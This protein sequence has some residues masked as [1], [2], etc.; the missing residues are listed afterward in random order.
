MGRSG[1]GG[2]DGLFAVNLDDAAVLDVTHVL[3][4]VE[5][6]ARLVLDQDGRVGGLQHAGGQLLGEHVDD[7][8]VQRV[9]AA[10]LVGDVH[11][12]R[13]VPI[14]QEQHA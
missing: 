14:L 5:D 4:L 6:V 13:L 8:G 9:Q 2:V 3:Q 10:Q 12:A 1:V 7:E 11:A